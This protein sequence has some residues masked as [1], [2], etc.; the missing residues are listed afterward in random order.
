MNSAEYAN[1]GDDFVMDQ[2]ELQ[3]KLSEEELLEIQQRVEADQ[4]RQVVD[5]EQSTPAPTGDVTSE[6]ATQ[7]EEATA[8]PQDLESKFK[9]PD[10]SIITKHW[11]QKQQHLINKTQNF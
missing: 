1:L 3:R 4:G 10:G 9:N 2:E 8:P 5:S 11:M 7:P 6:Q